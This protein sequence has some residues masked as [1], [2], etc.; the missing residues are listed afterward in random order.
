MGKNRYINTSFWDDDYIIGLQVK[1]KL[2]FLYLLTSPLNNISGMFSI[3]LSRIIFDTGMAEKDVCKALK[4]FEN[5]KKVFFIDNKFIIIANFIKHQK[6]NANIQKGIVNC[7]NSLPVFVKSFLNMDLTKPFEGLQDVRKAL[8]YININLNSNL[9][10][11]TNINI[12]GDTPKLPTPSK[13]KSLKP[14][15]IS[16]QVWDD[17]VTLRKAKKAPITETV[18]KGFTR[19]ANKALISLEEAILCTIDRNWTGFKSEWYKNNPSKSSNV[20]KEMI[21]KEKLKNGQKQ[22]S[23]DNGEIESCEFS[24]LS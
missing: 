2:L 11:N 22:I 5:D 10:L 1:E 9:N 15:E 3:H 16:Q 19:E 12:N 13:P 4:G 6:L 14:S 7:A 24:V 18:M 20:L 23:G 8:N 17:F 21:A